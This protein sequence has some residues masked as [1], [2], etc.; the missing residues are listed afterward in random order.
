MTALSIQ[1]TFPIFTDI[2]GQP[3][4]DGY[5]FIGTANLNPITNP[6]TVYWD[7]ALTLAAVQPIRTLGGYPMNSGTPARLYV[8]SDYSIQVQNKNGSLIYSAPA[9]TERLSGV[10]IEVDATDVSFIQAG[11][12]A[13]TRTAQA[14]MRE[15]VS[16]ADFGAD[17]TGATD[18][19]AAVQAFFNQAQA[20]GGDCIIPKGTYRVSSPILIYDTGT[21]RHDGARIRGSGINETIIDFRGSGRI[22]DIRGI[23]ASNGSGTQTGTYFIWGLELCDMTLNGANKT[24]TTDGIRLVGLWNSTFDNLMILNVQHG[25]VSDGDSTYN[26]NPDW[27]STANC[28]AINCN[29]ERLTGWGFYNT[30]QQAAPGWTFTHSLFNL[31]GS[32]GIYISSGGIRI[33]ECAFA[34]C[35][36]SSET[37]TPTANAAGLR[38][39]GSITASSQIVVENCEFDTNFAAHIDLEYAGGIRFGGNRYIFNDRYGYGAVCPTSGAVRIAAFGAGNAVRNCIFT[40]EFY[41]LDPGPTSGTPVGFNFVNNINVQEIR[42]FGAVFSDNNGSLNY[43]RVNGQTASNYWIRNNYHIEFADSLDLTYVVPGRPFAEYIGTIFD[44]PSTTGG[45]ILTVLKF[46]VRET[47]NDQIFGTSLYNTTTGVFTCPV[48]GYYDVDFLVALNST[49]STDSN[50]FRLYRNGGFV[51]EW[52]GNGNGSNRTY[53]DGRRRIFCNAGDT[54]DMRE[55]CSVSRVIYGSYS[56]LKISLNR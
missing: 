31:C 51:M 26:S 11:S 54:L 24:G 52:S 21:Q 48:A 36:W 34:G 38:I 30:V 47:V 33:S 37:A 16:L 40:N 14:K 53:Y 6:I 56:Y 13:V 28:K 32:G 17:P 39:S 42:A 12:G 29:F 7:A 3:L 45:N 8:N 22:I 44:L 2:D 23:P 55:V 35:G 25:I 20:V 5:V 19:T 1:P 15:T 18:S 27:S 10:V 43:T 46:D 50:A 4:E 41:R 49:I 9:A